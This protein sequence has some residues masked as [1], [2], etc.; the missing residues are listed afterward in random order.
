MFAI[1]GITGNVGGEVARNLHWRRNSPSRAVVRDLAQRRRLGGGAVAISRVR[2]SGTPRRSQ[3]RSR[4]SKESS[5]SSRR[6]SI[7]RQV[8]LRHKRLP[9]PSSPR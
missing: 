4:E 5:C 7:R 3:P 2:T 6:T 8:S 1:I 9:I